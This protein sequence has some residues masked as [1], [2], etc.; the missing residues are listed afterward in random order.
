[1]PL[2]KL[3]FLAKPEIRRELNLKQRSY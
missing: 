2:G 3:G 1:M